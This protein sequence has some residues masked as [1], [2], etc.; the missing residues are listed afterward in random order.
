MRKAET[1][2]LINGPKRPSPPALALRIAESRAGLIFNSVSESSGRRTGGRTSVAVHSKK[3][4][5]KPVAVSVTILANTNVV[6]ARG[7]LDD[8]DV[9]GM[10][11]ATACPNGGSY[12]S[13]EI[14][15]GYRHDP[16]LV[17]QVGTSV[18]RNLERYPLSDGMFLT[19]L[20]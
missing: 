14:V 20:G 9:T 2:D 8:P 5:G 11:I 4:C 18:E 16:A 7:A 3:S 12:S 19:E 15:L 1:D 17:V 10:E 6:A 13:I